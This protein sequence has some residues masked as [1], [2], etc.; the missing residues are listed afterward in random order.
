[1][2]LTPSG[3][4]L[5][6]KYFTTFARQSLDSYEFKSCLLSFFSAD[7]SASTFLENLD[8]DTW[9]YSPGLPPKPNYDTSLVDICYALAS[10]WEQ[11]A[12]AGG[13]G[14]D[15]DNEAFKPNA[16]DIKNMTSSQIV[17]FLE[18]VQEFEKPLDIENTRLMNTAY[19]FSKSN[20]AEILSRFLEIAL[21]AHVEELYQT[22]AKFLGEVGRMK[23]VRPL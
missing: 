23:F 6:T 3:L 7:K 15:D 19:A 5:F 8:W 20:N 21:K 12:T 17:V 22:T 16:S 2:L 9:F 14:G 11:K 13:G 4:T 18:R 10:K 1:M